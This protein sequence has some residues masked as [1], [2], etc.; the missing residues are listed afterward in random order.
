[1]KFRPPH[2]LIAAAIS[3][4]AASL[5]Q[6]QT[7]VTTDP[8]GFTTLSATGASSFISFDLQR[9]PDYAGIIPAGAVSASSTAGTLLTFPTGT[10]SGLV[11]SGSLNWH[12]IEITNGAGAGAI[13]M[14]VASDSSSIT[15]A[16]NISAVIDNAGGTT[17]FKTRPYWTFGTAFVTGTDTYVTG[18]NDL[19]AGFQG[20]TLPGNADDIS[21]WDQTK[22]IFVTYYFN[23][24]HNQWQ[25][26]LT[27]ANDAIIPPD[28]GM[29]M[30][31]RHSNA[32]SFV[33]QGG[34][35]LGT[36]GIYISGS[37]GKQMG[38][39]VSQP[40]PLS[41]VTLDNSGLYNVS[42]P[43]LGLLGGT[44][45]VNADTVNI[46]QPGSQ[47]FLS[48]YYNTTNSRWQQGLNPA[49]SYQ[50]PDGAAI[51]II[52]KNGQPF[53]WYVPQPTIAQ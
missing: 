53:T 28:H 6:A 38:N 31:L 33:L 29:L 35:K 52:R 24:T 44:L 49:G 9:N 39:F 17:T 11:L 4:A 27:P 47:T 3:L 14:I 45:A 36:T 15:V 37:S 50:I 42:N 34:V 13:S 7:T 21:I 43:S 51:L 30:Y 1:M 23:T 46:W 2:F 32:A 19:P 48:Y 18:T 25:Q 5:G 22:Q 20:G 10:L 41:S 16:D 26:G 12:Y 40:Y 8:V